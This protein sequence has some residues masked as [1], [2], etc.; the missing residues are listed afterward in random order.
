M[1]FN[2][3]LNRLLR[4]KAGRPFCHTALRAHKDLFR[5]NCMSA[6]FFARMGATEFERN[7][8]G[9]AAYAGVVAANGD[10]TGVLPEDIVHSRYIILWGS[11]PVISNQHLW[12]FILKARQNGAKIVVIDPFQSAS[13]RLAD[14]HIQPLPGT[15]IALAL[16][17]MHVILSEKLQDQDYMSRTR[18]VSRNSTIR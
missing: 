16:G 9:D 12:P 5:K 2:A 15:D 13:A 6:R 11:N 3:K 10:T 14:Q 1:K 7:I 8:C 17:M 4:K 18:Q